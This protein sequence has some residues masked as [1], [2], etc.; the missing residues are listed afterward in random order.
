[1]NK[2]FWQWFCVLSYAG[3]LLV[4]GWW[5]VHMDT[6]IL[7]FGILVTI[8]AALLFALKLTERGQDEVTSDCGGISTSSDINSLLE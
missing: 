1:M 6:P 7:F 5:N 8:S 3:I 4:L 2:Q